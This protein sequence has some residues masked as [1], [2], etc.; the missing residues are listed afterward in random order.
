MV[1]CDSMLRQP[2][3][4]QERVLDPWLV[5]VQLQ[6]FPLLAWL[7]HDR[8]LLETFSCLGLET[9]CGGVHGVRVGVVVS[10]DRCIY[11]NQRKQHLAMYD[12]CDGGERT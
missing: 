2:G 9:A 4:T 1:A 5:T 11:L 3:C 10:V 8:Y 7:L 6:G 12:G